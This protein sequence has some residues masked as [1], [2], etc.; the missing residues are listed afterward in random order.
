MCVK[1]IIHYMAVKLSFSFTHKPNIITSETSK[2]KHPESR[3]AYVIMCRETCES[4]GHKHVKVG[5]SRNKYI[6]QVII[7]IRNCIDLIKWEFL[8]AVYVACRGTL[9]RRT[10]SLYS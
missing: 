1:N 2:K 6:S 7:L 8:Y 5:A 10:L 9:D 3:S 4:L